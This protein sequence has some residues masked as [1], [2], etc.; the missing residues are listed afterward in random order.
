MPVANTCY[1]ISSPT[2]VK[3]FLHEIEPTLSRF[4]EMNDDS[5][6]LLL[7]LEENCANLALAYKIYGFYFN[8]HAKEFIGGLMNLVMELESHKMPTTPQNLFNDV[9]DTLRRLKEGHADAFALDY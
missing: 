2:K 8:A 7:K 5:A 6:N 3:L 4:I 1:L 9:Y